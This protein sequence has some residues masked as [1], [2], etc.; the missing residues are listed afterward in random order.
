MD[1]AVSS[2]SVCDV[3]SVIHSLLPSRAECRTRI[4]YRGD[5]T[6]SVDIPAVIYDKRQVRWP[7][8][9]FTLDGRPI[10]L[11]WVRNIYL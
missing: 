4:A 7:T 10:Q 9:L 5:I 2:P 1:R 3:W 6:Y 8:T 11:Q